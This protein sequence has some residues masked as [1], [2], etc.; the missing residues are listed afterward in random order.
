[1][2]EFPFV[3]LREWLDYLDEDNQLAHITTE[4]DL[5]GEVAA[6]ARHVNILGAS[7]KNAPALIMENIKGYPGWRIATNTFA[8]HERMSC[9]L[10]AD[11][12]NFLEDVTIGLDKRVSPMEVST[13]PCKDI[14]I[15]GDDIDLVKL[16]I[17]FVGLNEGTPSLTA[18][19]SIKK[20]ISTGWE[21]VAIRR[22]GLKGK[23]V[24]SEF[25]NP[26][27]QDFQIWAKYRER[28]EP[29]PV[30]YVIGPDPTT[31]I[32]SQTKQPRGVCEYDLVGVFT[33]APLELVRCETCDIMV[34]ATSE[35][36]IEG[37]ILPHERESD[38]P[39]PEHVGYY[40][41]IANVAR[42]DVKC[43]TMRKNPIFYFLDMGMPPTEGHN[44][45]NTMLAMSTYQELLKKFPGILDCYA[46][47]WV[48]PMVIKVKKEVAKSWPN[49]ASQVASLAKFKCIFYLKVVIVVDDDVEDIRDY[50]QVWNAIMSK[51][52][53]SK[54]V[55]I[56]PRTVATVLD[57]SEPWA[58]Q[59][60]WQDFFVMDCTEPAAPYDEGFKRGLAQPPRE[61][62]EKMKQNWDKYGFESSL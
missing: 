9:V 13:G 7:G 16:P 31:Y 10:G 54:D 44:M 19:M 4:V 6:L 37:E 46:H 60:G 8:T 26:G 61:F 2:L 53:A 40:S 48:G 25:I 29:M 28:N 12:D 47:G 20:D 36:I 52:Q 42:V 23:N 56:I 50:S 39:F 18:A 1:M 62:M 41:P 33:G 34:P 21:N 11:P 49:F 45:G 38:G 58:G 27:Q 51:F 43:I 55:T 15:K 5:K 59:W 57:A 14:I 22:L 35:I 17:P 24:L 3:S 32:I 30:A